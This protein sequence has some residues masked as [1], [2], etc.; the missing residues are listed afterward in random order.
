MCAL[1]LPRNPKLLL[2]L[3]FEIMPALIELVRVLIKL[4]RA[5]YKISNSHAL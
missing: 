5:L 4:V 3:I 1:L 2:S